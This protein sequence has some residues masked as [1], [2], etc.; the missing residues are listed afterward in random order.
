LGLGEQA[1]MKTVAPRPRAAKSFMTVLPP[2][3]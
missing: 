1:V 2:L 3:L